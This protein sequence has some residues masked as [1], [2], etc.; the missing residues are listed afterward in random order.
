MRYV[1]LDLGNV[2]L[3]IDFTS[4]EEAWQQLGY[5]EKEHYMDF[6]NDLHGQ[7]DVGL[8]TVMRHLKERFNTAPEDLSFMK[9]AWDGIV[10]PNKQ[11]L[12]FVRSLENELDTKVAILSNIGLEHSELLRT[13]YPFILGDGNRILHLSCEVGVRKPTKLYYQ[14]FV[15]DHPEF[16]GAVYLDDLKAN[17]ERGREYGFNSIQFELDKTLINGKIPEKTLTTLYNAITTN[18]I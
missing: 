5:H 9:E 4:F 8:T 15:W 6:L 7:Q 10:K 1:A 16:K 11:M 17:C 12:G 14:S 2:L 18:E 3:E 13:K